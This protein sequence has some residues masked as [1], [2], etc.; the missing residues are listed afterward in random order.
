[1][2]PTRF[3]CHGNSAPAYTCDAPGDQTGAYYRAEDVE[4][5]LSL[6]SGLASAAVLAFGDTERRRCLDLAVLVAAGS[7]GAE[8]EARQLIAGRWE[9]QTNLE[10]IAKQPKEHDTSR[11]FQNPDGSVAE[12]VARKIFDEPEGRSLGFDHFDD[13]EIL[14]EIGEAVAKIV[15]HETELLDFVE[16][17]EPADRDFDHPAG[18]QFRESSTG[19]GWRLLT[20]SRQPHYP[21]ARAA[22]RAAMADLERPTP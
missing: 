11:F 4:G 8:Q 20:T 13:E 16:D 7:D 1:M 5:R 6:L 10:R 14:F 19:R 9:R 18:W 12:S 15:G 2:N 3:D 22:I 17:H 21:T